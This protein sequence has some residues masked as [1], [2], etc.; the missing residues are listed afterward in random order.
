MYHPS[1]HI[2]YAMNGSEVRHVIVNGQLVME[3]RIV[4][5]IDT[6]TLFNKVR[7]LGKDIRKSLN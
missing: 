3:D 1:S 4:K 2:I 5:G 7:E 6:A